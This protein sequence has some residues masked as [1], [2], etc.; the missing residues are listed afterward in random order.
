VK[1]KVKVVLNDKLE[2]IVEDLRSA[3]S[4]YNEGYGSLECE[5]LR[6]HPLEVAYLR[7]KDRI[8]IF[9]NSKKVELSEFFEM[10]H[11]IDKLFWVKFVV[12]YDLKSRGRNVRPGFTENTLLLT[13]SKSPK[14]PSNIIVFVVE[15]SNLITL[16]KLIDWVEM[17][18]KNNKES[19]IAVVDRHGDVTYYEIGRF[20]PLRRR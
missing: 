14:E 5:T 16:R 6:L 17:A 12:Y 7:Y 15:E 18:S 2:G 13:P 20:E 10:L 8:E 3:Q 1:S 11:N 9:K 4:L 19:I